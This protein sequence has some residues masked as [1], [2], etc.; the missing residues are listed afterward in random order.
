MLAIPRQRLHSQQMVATKFRHP[1]EV[2]AWMGAI[3]AQDYP[4]AKWSL[5]LRLPNSREQ[6]IEQALAE[7]K[8]LRTWAMRGTL[9]FV[10]PRDI[11]WL[12]TLLAPRIIAG[13][14][15]RYQELELDGPTFGRS[16]AVIVK[17][18]AGGQRL[19]R[20]ELVAVLEQA[21]ISTAGQRTPYL[22][23]RAALELLIGQGV[24]RGKHPTYF[25]LEELVPP[26]K[27]LS[28]EEALAEL[29]HRYFTSR[30][31]ATLKDFI[32]WSG[33]S[34]VDAAAGLAA[35]KAQLAQLAIGGRS[36][37]LSGSSPDEKPS[38]ARLH[39]LPGFDE[40]L[41]SYQD[42][43]AVMDWPQL[44]RLTPANGMLPPTLVWDGRVVGIWKRVYKKKGT[45]VITA[46]PYAKLVADERQSLVA[47]ARQYGEFLGLDVELEVT[48][49]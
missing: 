26:A 43:S 45:V 40:Y 16:N 17:A 47:A 10:A 8:I 21:G 25:L 27:F 2:L 14:A 31:P 7:A 44:R 5:G 42:R 9:H 22:L 49:T 24:M 29:A 33:L 30:G 19:A 36:Y 20:P 18:L 39:L 28:R 38:K 48:L 11:R 13:N 35:V 46:K 4:G 32:W 23:Q 6:E 37:W 12:L 34:S 41:L 1:A 3:Q 15:R